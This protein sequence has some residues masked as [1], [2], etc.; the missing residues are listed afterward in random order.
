MAL[1][2]SFSL[3][4]EGAG[5]GVGESGMLSR[6]GRSRGPRVFTNRSISSASCRQPHQVASGALAHAPVGGSGAFQRQLSGHHPRGAAQ[7][8]F[9]ALGRPGGRTGSPAPVEFTGLV[10]S[11]GDLPPEGVGARI[12]EGCKRV[13]PAHLSRGLQER[14]GNLAVDDSSWVSL[15]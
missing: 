11:R 13:D 14:G 6:W 8:E 12:A 3:S 4:R 9:N 15:G 1:R 5:V 2:G 7:A 10:K